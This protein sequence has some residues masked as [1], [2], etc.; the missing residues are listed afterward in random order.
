MSFSL[1]LVPA[2]SE[3]SA[4]GGRD[5]VDAEERPQLSTTFSVPYIMYLRLDGIS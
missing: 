5:I 2:W 3:N 1:W 4:E